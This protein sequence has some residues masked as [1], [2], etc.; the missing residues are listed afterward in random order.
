MSERCVP[1]ASLRESERGAMRDLLARHF[2][3]VDDEVFERDLSAKDRVVLVEK[4][5]GEL[6]GFSTFA[7]HAAEV[8]GRRAWIVYSGD[9]IVDPSVWNEGRLARAWI[10]SML[11]IHSPNSDEPLY[12]LL[13]VSGYRTYRFLP[14]FFREFWPRH[15][16][17]TPRE[18]RTAIETLARSRFDGGYD[19]ERGIV[20]LPRPSVLREGLRGIPIHRR[21]NPHVAF[22]SRSNPDHERGDELVC[23]TE[24]C[25]HNL[26][27]AGRR[28]LRAALR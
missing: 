10:R 22:F 28:V 25:P 16:R 9:T 5:D 13:I 7:Y 26:T 17:T 11:A 1:V 18:A 14:V 8:G 23:L 4:P 2:E 21:R 27:R 15:D 19:P 3:S 20:R 12:W 24:V 6:V